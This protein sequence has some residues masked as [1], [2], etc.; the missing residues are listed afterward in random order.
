[1]EESVGPGARHVAG[2]L[3][4]RDL[5]VD[6]CETVLLA[7]ATRWSTLVTFGLAR[8]TLVAGLNQD[9]KENQ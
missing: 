6:T 1:M 8:S 9:N 7:M 4:R 3:M 5:F 2:L